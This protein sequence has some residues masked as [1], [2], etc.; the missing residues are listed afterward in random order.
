MEIILI[1]YLP[2]DGLPLEPAIGQ[3]PPLPE[4]DPTWLPSEDLQGLAR[5]HSGQSLE[6]FQGFH[7]RRRRRRRCHHQHL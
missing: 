7:R 4:R 2:N 6:G 3:D 5:V 1:R